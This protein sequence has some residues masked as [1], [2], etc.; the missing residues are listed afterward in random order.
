M[1]LLIATDVARRH[2]TVFSVQSASLAAR[3][4]RAACQLLAS[5][6]PHGTARP[7]QPQKPNRSIPMNPS[8]LQGEG[9][10]QSAR[11][12]RD[13][14]KRFIEAGRVEEAARLAAPTDD[15]T[16]VELQR[17]EQ[18]AADRGHEGWRVEKRRP[19]GPA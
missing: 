1:L 12:Y 5:I 14:L 19:D 9:D 8:K 4:L 17:A 18:E 3:M 11:R 10:Y 16:A 7:T 2:A 6:R 15:A 13:S